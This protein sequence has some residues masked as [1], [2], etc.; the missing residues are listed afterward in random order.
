MTWGGEQQQLFKEVTRIHPETDSDGW[1]L[2]SKD[3]PGCQRKH[4]LWISPPGSI[5][6]PELQN[7]TRCGL[8]SSSRTFFFI[9][10][11]KTLCISSPKPGL[12]VLS[13]AWIQ[14]WKTKIYLHLLNSLSPNWEIIWTT[15]TRTNT[16]KWMCCC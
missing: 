4:T 16:L 5:H 13:F 6:D 8:Y 15:K 12:R 2:Q 11:H 14:D 10:L 9:S 7:R 3:W 1:V